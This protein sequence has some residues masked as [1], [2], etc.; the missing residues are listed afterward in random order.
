MLRLPSRS[1]ISALKGFFFPARRNMDLLKEIGFPVD[2]IPENFCC[3]VTFEIMDHPMMLDDNS[4]HIVENQFLLEFWSKEREKINPFTNEIVKHD[5]TPCPELKR[6]INAFVNEQVAFYRRV[7][8]S[9]DQLK[10]AFE[11]DIKPFSNVERSIQFNLE[12]ANIPTTCIDTVLTGNIMTYP[13]KLDESVTVDLRA[14]LAWWEENPSHRYKNPATLE[15]ITSITMDH[16][17]HQLLIL[18]FDTLKNTRHILSDDL[19]EEQVSQIRDL[20]RR[21]KSAETTTQRLIAA[22]FSS[23]QL[24]HQQRKMLIGHNLSD[25]FITYPV[26]I[27][28]QYDMDF[29]ELTQWWA[30]S[31]ANRYCNFYTSERIKSIEYNQTLKMKIEQ[32]IQDPLNLNTLGLRALLRNSNSLSLGIFHRLHSQRVEIAADT[33]EQSRRLRDQRS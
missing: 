10:V 28:D 15:Y 27:D 31:P 25:D 20:I 6:K 26:R 24:T 9:I 29:N 22:G 13:V 32:L 14:L 16:D 8:D 1:T 18:L 12:I 4:D 5:P 3:A 19:I 30:L 33:P 11:Y 2:D 7:K 21:A 23:E 17:I